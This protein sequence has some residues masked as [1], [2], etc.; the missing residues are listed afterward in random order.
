MSPPAKKKREKKEEGENQIHSICDET[1]PHLQVGFHQK[2]K[3]VRISNPS[4]PP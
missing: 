4:R 3:R 1:C 2:K